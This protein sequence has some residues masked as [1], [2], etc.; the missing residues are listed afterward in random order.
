MELKDDER[1]DDL[2]LNGLKLIQNKKSFCF[3]VDA[4]LLSDFV[5]VKKDEIALDLGTGTGILPILLSAK[6]KGDKFH[7]LEIQKESADLAR[8]N[9]EINKLSDRITITEGDIKNAE[10]FYPLSSFDVVLTN[11]PYMKAGAGILNDFTPKAIAKHEILVSLYDIIS[12]SA[13]LLKP[14]G[15]FYMIHR[16]KRLTDIFRT[17][18]E[19]R[20]EV[21]HI[22][23]VHSSADKEAALVML[24]AIRG[25]NEGLKVLP[26][27]V[28]DPPIKVFC[29][30]FNHPLR[31][32]DTAP[33]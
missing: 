5:Q 1:L 27:N 28:I 6:T 11:P 3:G 14:Q 29:E 20:L 10:S 32:G 15:R 9:V 2:Q 19:F 7:A 8:R 24:E 25:G 4:V 30:N 22:Q 13:K 18:S 21:K 33:K 31:K 12:K 23:F 17:L 26:P 16:P